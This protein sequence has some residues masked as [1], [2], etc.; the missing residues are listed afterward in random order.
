M[1]AFPRPMKLQELESNQRLD[2][3]CSYKMMA[4]LAGHNTR[5][6]VYWVF[7]GGISSDLCISSWSSPVFSPFIYFL[8]TMK[9]RIS[10]T[11]SSCHRDALP[12]CAEPRAHSLNPLKS[13]SL[14]VFVHLVIGTLW[15]V[16]LTV[17][18]TACIKYVSVA[19]TKLYLI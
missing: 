11:T 1:V 4:F 8:I 12:R 17:S 2:P 5:T 19:T 14:V 13:A 3:W 18:L 7:S 10:S 9:G 15:I 16:K 6:R